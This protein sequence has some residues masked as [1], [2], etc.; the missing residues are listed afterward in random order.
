MA[1]KLT[2]SLVADLWDS[3][4]KAGANPLESC[5]KLSSEYSEFHSLIPDMG[6]QAFLQVT[7]LALS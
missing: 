1:D 7:S 4:S 2:R 5:K 6:W 3:D